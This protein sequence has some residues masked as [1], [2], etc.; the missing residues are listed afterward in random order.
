MNCVIQGVRLVVI[1]WLC[2]ASCVRM[3]SLC[4]VGFSPGAVIPVKLGIIGVVNR[5]Q[6]DIDKGKVSIPLSCTCGHRH[7]LC[8]VELG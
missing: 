5:S 8:A 2:K 1:V 4:R 7:Q 3:Y 6:E